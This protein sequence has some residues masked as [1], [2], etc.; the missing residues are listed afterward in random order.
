MRDKGS[1]QLPA[2]TDSA[3]TTAEIVHILCATGPHC[4]PMDLG[5]TIYAPITGLL[6]RGTKTAFE[7]TSQLTISIFPG[8]TPRWVVCRPDW[9]RQMPW[10][11]R[12]REDLCANRPGLHVTRIGGSRWSGPTN[13]EPRPFMRTARRKEPDWDRHAR[14]RD[15]LCVPAVVQLGDECLGRD[16]LCVDNYPCDLRRRPTRDHLCVDNRSVLM[17]AACRASTNLAT[18]HGG[19]AETILPPRSRK[20]PG[21]W[22]DLND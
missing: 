9:G 20:L 13:S 21:A 6:S 22:P 7:G 2:A 19:F 17:P 18:C 11:I 5:A 4:D 16:H 10:L 15:H 1:C 12:E 8:Q 3:C 14:H